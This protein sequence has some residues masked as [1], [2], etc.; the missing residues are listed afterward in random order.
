MSSASQFESILHYR[1]DAVCLVLLAAFASY[2]CHL[3]LRHRNAGQDSSRATCG[4]I[5]VLALG[6]ALLAEWI[7][8][9]LDFPPATRATSLAIARA[10]ALGGTAFLIGVLLASATL[11]A[12]MRAEVRKHTAAERELR[13]ARTTADAANRGPACCND[14]GTLN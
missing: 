5:V 9:S 8:A 1:L 7:A 11:L 12:L 14:V 4:V 3:F 10:M 13:R 6:G 2:G